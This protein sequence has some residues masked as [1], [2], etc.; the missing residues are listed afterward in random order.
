VTPEHDCMAEHECSRLCHLDMTGTDEHCNSH[1]HSNTLSW[2]DNVVSQPVFQ[3]HAGSR[4]HSGT[5]QDFNPQPV[6]QPPAGFIYSPQMQVPHPPPA[7][8]KDPFRMYVPAEHPGFI[9]L[10][11]DM[12]QEQNAPQQRVGPLSQGGRHFQWQLP[13]GLPVQPPAPIQPLIQPPAPTQPPA[14]IV[15]G[16]RYAAA[17]QRYCGHAQQIHPQYPN[18]LSNHHWI[19]TSIFIMRVHSNNWFYNSAFPRFY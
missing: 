9:N 10:S 1:S 3:S 12:P 4:S 8:G 18:K 16:V 7:M 17:N 11:N 19:C 14:Q 6:L 13:S 2:E 5:P 15:A